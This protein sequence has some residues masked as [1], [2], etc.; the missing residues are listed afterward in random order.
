MGWGCTPQGWLR[1]AAG[2]AEQPTCGCSPPL[3]PHPPH[4]PTMPPTP[5]GRPGR[6]QG[7]PHPGHP[8]DPGCGARTAVA[9]APAPAAAR[10]CQGG[11]RALQGGLGR[12]FSACWR[13]ACVARGACCHSGCSPGGMCSGVHHAAAPAHVPARRAWGPRPLPACSCLRWGMTTSLSTPTVGAAAPAS[14]EQGVGVHRLRLPTYQAVPTCCRHRPPPLL[15][16]APWPA[17]C[18]VGDHKG[19]GLGA[20]E[21]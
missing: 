11:A 16:H 2:S 10:S 19:P 1:S 4:P 21:R 9:G 6:H 8:A 13:R 7:R 3:H 18:S 12:R 17:A 15:A 20:A 5:G 14:A